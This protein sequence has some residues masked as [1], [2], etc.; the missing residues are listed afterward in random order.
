MTSGAVTAAPATTGQWLTTADGATWFFDSGALCLDFGYTG[1]FG[2][3]VPAWEQLRTSGAADAWFAARFGDSP[4]L[5]DATDLADAHALRAAITATAR[6]A[7]TGQA[8]APSDVDHINDWASLPGIP[9]RLAGG[10][11]RAPPATPTQ[12][13]ATVAR[14]AVTTFGPHG[15]RVRECAAEDCRLIFVDT[16]R[17][18][19]RRWCSMRRCGN[20]AKVRSHYARSH[21]SES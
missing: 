4:R 15:T 21:E 19:S 6:R 20:R 8:F 10:T 5:C 13:L 12:M 9:L 11:R 2:Y 3:G 16:S 14:D 17:P 7:A 1:D 18:G